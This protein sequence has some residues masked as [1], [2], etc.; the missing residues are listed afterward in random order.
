MDARTALEL[1]QRT[2]ERLD[3]LGQTRPRWTSA[4]IRRAL[5]EAEREA[6]LRADLIHDRTTASIVRV[7]VSAGRSTALLHPSV[8]TVDVVERS[9][10]GEEVAQVDEQTMRLMDAGWRSREGTQIEH[11][12]VQ[13]LPN[14]RIQLR[15]YPIPLVDDILELQVFRLPR[16]ELEADDDEPEIA[17]R[18]HEHLV[19]WAVYRCFSRRDPDTYDP[20]RAQDALASFTANF[21]ERD[22]AAQMRD[23]RD[24]TRNIVT[25]RDY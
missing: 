13:V 1:E 22:T 5:S 23:Q 4:E 24:R 3:D 16:N 8:Y 15:L 20:A 17:P 6:C 9:S 18:H 10:D 7:P 25:A 19:D 12:I 14:E 21:G 11:F 2:R